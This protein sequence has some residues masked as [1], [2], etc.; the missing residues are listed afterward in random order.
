MVKYVCICLLLFSLFS[1]ISCNIQEK[2]SMKSKDGCFTYSVRNMVLKEQIIKYFNTVEPLDGQHKVLLIRVTDEDPFVIYGLRYATGIQSLN[3]GQVH[4]VTEVQG[5]TVCV[6]Y[7]RVDR[8][9][10]D[11]HLSDESML[12]IMKSKFPDDYAHFQH[13]MRVKKNDTVLRKEF[14]QE[15]AYP[16]P[17]TGGTELWVLKFK[18]G[19]LIEKEISW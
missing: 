2:K 11:F 1:N 5:N 10:N 7:N 15:N 19:K 6:S 17:V 3:Y 16:V 14:S 18:D 12:K 4:T 8:R 13:K 9:V